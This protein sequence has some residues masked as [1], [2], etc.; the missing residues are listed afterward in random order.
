MSRKEIEKARNEIFALAEQLC[1]YK[2]KDH[3]ITSMD[4]FKEDGTISMKRSV[5]MDGFI[6]AVMT[7]RKIEAVTGQ[8]I[9]KTT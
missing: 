8:P 4:V 6:Q 5:W 7:I 9:N 2:G 3:V 1:P